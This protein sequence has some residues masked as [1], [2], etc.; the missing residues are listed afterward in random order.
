MSFL[1]LVAGSPRW[2]CVMVSSLCYGESP[3]NWLWVNSRALFFILFFIAGGD[4]IVIERERID[5]RLTCI[6]TSSIARVT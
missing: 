2:L 6:V 5:V 1:I 3:V 4:T